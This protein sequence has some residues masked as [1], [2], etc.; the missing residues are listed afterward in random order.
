MSAKSP[1][2]TDTVTA[3]TGNAPAS[4]GTRASSARKSTASIQLALDTDSV[5]KAVASARKAGRDLTV[6][7]WTKTHCNACLIAPVM[8]PLTSIRKLVLVM[9]GGLETTVLKVNLN[10]YKLHSDLRREL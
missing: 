5:L 3:S 8:E 4:E 7:P 1:T 10:S 9:L 6:P 2:A